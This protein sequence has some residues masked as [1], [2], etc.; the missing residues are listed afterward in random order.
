MRARGRSSPL[1]L[2]LL[3]PVTVLACTK[4]T[5]KP[6]LSP[7]ELPGATSTSP[8]AATPAPAEDEVPID[9]DEP[10]LDVDKPVADRCWWS[11]EEATAAC[12]VSV[13]VD[14]GFKDDLVFVG[15]KSERVA[16]VEHRAS[17]PARNDGPP[18]P[19]SILP[20][21][22]RERIRQRLGAG[23]Y[24]PVKK[25]EC[26][27]I[28]LSDVGGD[29]PTKWTPVVTSFP[30]ASIR[31][32]QVDHGTPSATGRSGRAEGIYEIA[33]T[34]KSLKYRRVMSVTGGSLATTNKGDLCFIDERYLLIR[35]EIRG[36]NEAGSL[37]ERSAALVDLERECPAK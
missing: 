24:R 31:L 23:H 4:G 3:V 2:V 33:C 37:G 11:S 25:S 29:D 36:R 5:T 12:K 18:E 7:I 1:L 20:K 8:E 15:A 19:T 30:Q 22:S 21:K 28:D 6:K 10:I 26:V 27:E 34:A 13:Y 9:A 16:I 32:R 17:Q 14:F 35:G